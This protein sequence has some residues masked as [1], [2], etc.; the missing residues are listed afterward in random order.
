MAAAG[1]GRRSGRAVALAA[2]LASGGCAHLGVVS[3]GTSVSYGA[4]NDGV[5][6][7]GVRM[8]DRGPGYWAP[9]MWRNRGRRY[10]TR[11]LVEVLAE[12]AGRVAKELPGARLGIA[13]LSV[14]G[15]GKISHHQSHQTGRDADVL[16]YVTDARGKAQDATAMHRFNGEGRTLEAPLRFDVARNWALVR[17]LITSPVVRVQRIFVFEPLAQLLLDHARATDEPG[18]MLDLARSVMQQPSDAAP[19]DDHFHIR[20]G[21][22][23]NDLPYGCREIG[24]VIDGKPLPLYA[25]IAVP[26]A[27]PPRATAR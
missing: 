13:D 25:P 1:R 11:E 27:G 6:L 15:G 19:H 16:F 10:G 26:A 2:L 14:Q 20:V 18:A 4:P 23:D 5:L 3:D 22:A 7:D 12:A 8:P 24:R 17:A 9:S 21:C